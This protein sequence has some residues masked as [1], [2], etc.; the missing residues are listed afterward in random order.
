MSGAIEKMRRST[1]SFAPV[2]A[3]AVWVRVRHAVGEALTTI[4]RQGETHDQT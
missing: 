4:D 3:V 2:A 1:K